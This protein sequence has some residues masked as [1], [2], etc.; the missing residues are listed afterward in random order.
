MAVRIEKL[1]EPIPGYR[2][3][4][5][6]GGGGFGEV[7][8]CEAPGGLHKAI[9][10]VYGDLGAAGDDGHRAEQELKAL[11]RVK[12]VRHPYILSLERY[13]IL[14]GQLLIVMELADRNL[15]DRFKECRAEGM[16]GIPREE[17]LCYLEETA[18]ALDLMNSLYQLQHLD[19]KPQNLFLVHN[20][21]KV[22]DFGLVKDL[23]GMQASVTGGVTPV[24][25]APETFDGWVSRFSDQYSLG[26]VFQELLTG[27]RP[28]VGMNVR[29]LI[30][31]HIQ[32]PPNVNPLPPHDRPIVS[33]SLAKKPDERYPCCRDFVHALRN[34]AAGPGKAASMAVCPSAVVDGAKSGEQAELPDPAATPT[35]TDDDPTANPPLTSNI[36]LPIPEDASPLTTTSI[37]PAKRGAPRTDSFAPRRKAAQ[38]TRGDGV[39]FPALV[40]GLGQMGLQALQGLRETVYTH[41]GGIDETPNLRLLLLD[42]D[43]EVLRQGTRSERPGGAL[44]A[45]E[46]VL[47]PLNRP[48]Y[49]LKPREGRP[50]LDKWLPTRMIYRIP[51]SQ[52]TTGVRALGRLAFCDHY[53]AIHRRLASELDA[54]L[55]PEPLATA[56]QRTRLGMR[57]NRPRVYVVC[58]LGGGTGSGMFL[59]V[60]YTLRALLTERG[61]EQ[62]DVVGILLLPQVDRNF[63]HVQALGNAHAALV[64][65][66][67]FAQPGNC[68]TAAY[69]DRIPAI[70]DPEPPFSRCI[71]LPMLDETDEAGT[72]SLIELLSQ[73]FYRDLFAPLGKSAD[74][75]R[76]ELAG[77]AWE[78]RGLHYNTFNLYEVSWPRHALLEF[79]SRRLCSRLTQRWMS[80]DSKPI[81]EQVQTWVKEE[82]TRHDL[83]ADEFINRLARLCAEKV[84]DDPETACLAVLQPLLDKYVTPVNTP[85]PAGRSRSSKPLP[86]AEIPPDE[87]VEIMAQLEELL[88]KPPDDGALEPHGR[89]V[90]ALREASDELATFWG[91]KLAEMPVRL[92]EEPDYRLAGA[93]EAVRQTVAA[94]EQILQHHEPLLQDLTTRAREAFD[95]LRLLTRPPSPQ[96]REKHKAWMEKVSSA[97]GG[98]TSS[99]RAAPPGAQDVLELL[100]CYAKW[101]YQALVLSQVAAAFVT[102]R[103]H[104]A[105]EMREIN[106][107]RVRLGEL[108]RMFD[109]PGGTAPAAMKARCGCH[110]FPA[111]GKELRQ[112]VDDFLASIGPEAL[113]DLDGRI[114]A[115]FKD[116]FRAL[117]HICLAE[118]NVLANVH[119]AMLETTRAFVSERVGEINVAALFLNQHPDEEKALA[120]LSHYFEQA[121]PPPLWG[122]G[123][124]G[125]SRAPRSRGTQLCVLDAPV[126]KE[127]D[128]FRALA[129]AVLPDATVQ[130]AGGTSADTIILYREI[131]H[132]PLADLE[133]LGPA[134][135][136]PYTQMNGTNNFTLHTRAD[137]PFSP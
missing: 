63:T 27:Q 103:G 118:G 28:F 56:A 9:K 113:H 60:A 76:A 117:V 93:E 108:Q 64:E 37:G 4:E 59:D 69:D 92:I 23:E 26:I 7:W 104:L 36:R 114:E 43:A 41:L 33:R 131:A 89:I 88:G 120:T 61:Y 90:L 49:Y 25:A 74:L 6:L 82:W 133:L 45:A 70:R 19:I 128:N 52:V 127:G 122:R 62:P 121:A 20:H 42:T 125:G 65:L 100:R 53:R 39:L 116:Q 32:T 106:F 95:L 21:V 50:A 31:Q 67:H 48:S 137:V 15:W 135:Q 111:A 78:Q 3:L 112:A 105:D 13:D 79:V 54:L 40:I 75:A 1:A 10:F 44:A 30:L 87:I 132:L 17:L 83:S 24:Y 16:P 34:A 68:F 35:G 97:M 47:A 11:S 126:G 110:L 55:E 5:R 101:R 57:T 8:K 98:R 119:P 124:A 51:R 66:N 29:Q 58:S 12:T 46:V 94:I 136:Q 102:L 84:G 129:K 109:E 123:Q 18:E 73:Y 71:L 134:G 85:G 115:R 81:R 99:Q 130:H 96:S 80:K 86:S 14:D 107:C 22:A 77:P 91:Q 72:S 2:L 38:E